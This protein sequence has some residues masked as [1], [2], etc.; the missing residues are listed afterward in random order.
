M[1]LTPRRALALASAAIAL[2]LFVAYLANSSLGL[3]SF[4]LLF[5]VTAVYLD[6]SDSVSELRRELEELRTELN[7]PE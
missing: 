3:P 5:M 1:R 7:D 2:T 4:G 6:L